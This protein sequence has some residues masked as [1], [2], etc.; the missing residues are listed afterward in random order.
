M[1]LHHVDLGGTGRPPLLLLHGLLGSS[2]NWQT[3]GRDLAES[4]HVFALDA[5]NHGR[6]PH[7][8]TASPEL[9]MRDV[10]GWMDA[11]DMAAAAIIGH[12]MGG[13]TAML[14]ACRHPAR[15]TRLV[16][17]DV[18]PRDYPG[19]GHWTHFDALL[20]LDLATLRSRQEAEERLAASV[21]D[22]G[23][24]KFLVTNLA[25][26]DSGRWYWTVNLPVLAS[27]LPAFEANPLRPDDRY[28]GPVL[29]IRGGRS[30]YIQPGDEP[31]IRAHFPAAR[32]AT[33]ADAGHN[34]HIDRREEFV[35]LVRAIA[36]T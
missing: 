21:S 20:A 35:T 28:A 26:D 24:R 36:R 33:I 16:V 34:P 8:A 30:S 18:A 10:T 29:F 9:M 22:L 15:V 3:T 12:S 27:S 5:R 23:Q 19:L 25:Q 1:L 2:R 4:Y 31:A 32:V 17:V 11:R 6:S 13:R 14:L 7:A